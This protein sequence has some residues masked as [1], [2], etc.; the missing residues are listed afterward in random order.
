[1]RADVSLGSFDLISGCVSQFLAK[2]LSAV[3]H[4]LL[5]PLYLFYI[6]CYLLPGVVLH[7]ARPERWL[8][9]AVVAG[10]TLGL[11]GLGTVLLV[12]LGYADS[13]ELRQRRQRTLP[14][15]L[16]AV[17][18]ATTAAWLYRP[19]FIDGLLF[20]LMAGMALAVLLTLLVTLRWQISAHGVGMGGAFGLLLL[21]HLGGAAGPVGA[22]WLAATAGLAGA[23]G[24]ARLALAAHSPAQVWAGLGLGLAVAVAAGLGAAI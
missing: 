21:L 24:S 20:W 15:L 2:V 16:A 22:L 5:V 8:V 7:P 4:P 18:F 10:G 6:V 14:L 1:M 3:F 19:V 13:V 23:V 17:S 11:P 12:K 9:L